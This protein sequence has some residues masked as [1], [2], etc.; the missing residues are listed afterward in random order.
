MN[1]RI[2]IIQ[3]GVIVLLLAAVFAFTKLQSKS[4][5]GESLADKI[6]ILV[7]NRTVVILFLLTIIIVGVELGTIGILTTYLMELR[8]FTQFSSKIGLLFFL[9]GIAIG[10]LVIGLLTSKDKIIRNLKVLFGSGVLVFF[11]L[12][13]LDLDRFAYLIIFI[14]GITISAMLPLVITLAGLLYEDITGTVIGAIKVGIPIGGI[15]IPFIMSLVVNWSNL[16]TSLLVFPLAFLLAFCLAFF[17]IGEVRPA[18]TPT[19][20]ED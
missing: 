2:S 7:R 3:A 4:G 14:A 6:R 1:W 16:Q 10:R 17:G 18:N 11:G 5:S 12:Y 9:A 20:T 19:N 8:Q 15:L 13:F